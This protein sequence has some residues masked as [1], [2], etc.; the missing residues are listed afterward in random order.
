MTHRL[1]PTVIVEHVYHFLLDDMTFSLLGR[2]QIGIFYASHLAT[3]L[4][5]SSLLRHIWAK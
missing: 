3:R 1:A 4:A 5:D 2:E